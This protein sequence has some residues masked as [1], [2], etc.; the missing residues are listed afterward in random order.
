[1]L[2]PANNF[3]FGH[4]P[5]SW[6]SKLR[7]NLM[8]Q[9]FQEKSLLM[10]FMSQMWNNSIIKN[11]VE[12]LTTFIFNYVLVNIDTRK[13]EGRPSQKIPGISNLMENKKSFSLR[14]IFL[15]GKKKLNKEV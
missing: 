8:Q 9:K 13:G 6:N 14:F 3:L 4:Q 5:E 10:E 11:Q 1:M 15:F 2:T 12:T 7:K